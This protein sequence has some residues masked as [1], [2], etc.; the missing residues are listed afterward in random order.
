MPTPENLV[1]WYL[2]LNGFMTIPTYILHPVRPGAQRTD[3]DIVG[4]RFPYRK[5]F[6]GSDV[7]DRRLTLDLSKPLLVIVEVKTG[8]MMRNATWADPEKGNVEKL[9]EC[10][11][12]FEEQSDIDEA[13]KHLYQAGRYE[14]SEMICS[15]VL[16]VIK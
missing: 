4:I 1:N 9:L 2:R 8:A 14:N 13:A 12:I 5:E 16:V 15:F 3:A 6:P 10:V 11:G 7:D